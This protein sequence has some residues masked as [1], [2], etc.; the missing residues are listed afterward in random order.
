MAVTDKIAGGVQYGATE[1]VHVGGKEAAVATIHTGMQAGAQTGT[2]AA[3]A[4]MI[5]GGIGL[6]AAVSAAVAQLDYESKRREMKN[7]LR[8]ELAS[9]TGKSENKVRVGDLDKLAKVNN[10]VGEQMAKEKKLRNIGF[11]TISG[12]TFAAVGI[13]LL[14]GPAIAA[15]SF[16]AS[17]TALSFIANAAIAIATYSLVKRPL[18]KLGL[19]LFGADKKTSFERIEDMQKEHEVGKAISRER[20]FAVFVQSNPELDNFIRARYGKKFDDLAVADKIALTDLIGSKLGVDQMTDDINHGRVKATEL[21]FAVE[22]KISGVLPKE[23]ESPKHSVL[24]TIKQKLHDVGD[25]VTHPVEH[26]HQATEKSFVERLGRSPIR[27]GMGHVQQ[28][29]ES[30][31]TGALSGRGA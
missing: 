14:A 20:V 2:L 6:T 15:I 25:A 13:V 22:G 16:L 5:A 7:L 30:R 23:G 1:V 31:A 26:Y 3:G 8:G 12:A 4:G 24:M 28:I 11:A 19:K 27:T 29:E 21:V 9:V 18:D 17:S 10:T